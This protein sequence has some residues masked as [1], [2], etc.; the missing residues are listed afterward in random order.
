MQTDETECVIEE[1]FPVRCRTCGKVISQY[2]RPYKKFI[3]DGKTAKEFFDKLKLRSC[4]RTEM[5]CPQ[6]ISMAPRL[7]DYDMFRIISEK[8]KQKTQNESEE[9]ASNLLKNLSMLTEGKKQA[10]SGKSII[11]ETK[12]KNVPY[13]AV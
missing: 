6:K 13:F 2:E 8:T 1:F 12:Y 3:N 10:M 7:P 11:D 9:K 4:C 5:L